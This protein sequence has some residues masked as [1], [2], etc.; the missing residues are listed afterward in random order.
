M[1]YE[2]LAVVAVVAVAVFVASVQEAVSNMPDPKPLPK[3]GPTVLKG[4]PSK[5]SPE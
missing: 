2:A 5:F 3:V 4:R 1:R